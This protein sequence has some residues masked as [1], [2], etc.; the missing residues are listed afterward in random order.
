MTNTTTITADAGT[1]FYDV[2]RDFD[3][4]IEA[5]FRAHTEPELL[6][7]WMGPREAPVHYVEFEPKAGGRWRFEGRNSEGTSEFEFSGVFHSVEPNSRIIQTFEFSLAP[8]EVGIGIVTFSE[9]DGRTRMISHEVYPSVEARDAAV[10]S[11]MDY[12]VIE[13][14]ERLDELLLSST[15]AR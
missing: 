12:G 9:V 11:G 8:G 6:D 5:V 2:V 1:P 3:A 4:P 10:G 14:Y 7:Q 15:T 13:G